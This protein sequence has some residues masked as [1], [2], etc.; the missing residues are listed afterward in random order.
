M[1]NQIDTMLPID[2]AA[3][4]YNISVQSI[5]TMIDSGKIRAAMLNQIGIVV[6]DFD[7]ANQ[8]PKEDQPNYDKNLVGKGIGLRDASRK[9][10]IP[11]GTISNWVK[12]GFIKIISRQ[13]VV[14][15]Y[16]TLLDEAD[17]AYYAKIRAQKPGKGYRPINSDGTQHH[18]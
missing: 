13:S 2:E 16:K 4:R 14:G 12:R 5:D 1:T 18:K 8:L 17:V 3:S 10:S 6:S 15:G 11:L 9:Y 7:L